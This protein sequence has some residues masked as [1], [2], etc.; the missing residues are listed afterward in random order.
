MPKKK[1]EEKAEFSYS[2]DELIES[3]NPGA[4]RLYGYS[5]EEMIGRAVTRLIPD[6]KLREF[7]ELHGRLLRGDSVGRIETVHQRKDGTAV[8]V[9]LVV[10][11]V[12]GASGRLAA[13][14]IIASK[15][16]SKKN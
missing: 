15:L 14:G 9:S 10:S 12:R 6:D 3:W 11:A 5:S 16:E 7:A 8:P 13:V 1:D 4:Q 2:V